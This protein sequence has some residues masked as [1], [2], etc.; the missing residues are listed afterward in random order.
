MTT[1]MMKIEMAGQTRTTKQTD[2]A[3]RRGK[4]MTLAQATGCT[5]TVPAA[6][7]LGARICLHSRSKLRRGWGQSACLGLGFHFSDNLKSRAHSLTIVVVSAMKFSRQIKFVTP[8]ATQF[9]IGSPC[10]LAIDAI[11][12]KKSC[13]RRHCRCRC[14]SR[15]CGSGRCNRASVWLRETVNETD[16]R[17]LLLA[18]YEPRQW[19]M[20]NDGVVLVENSLTKRANFGPFS[21][22]ASE[23][24]IDGA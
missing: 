6:V 1:M 5:E 19:N 24:G 10:N 3:M 14:R 11:Q 7:S 15:G 23:F 21:V 13:C 18:V 12:F 20:I 9:V 8:K 17:Q 4:R 22:R 16:I 2:A